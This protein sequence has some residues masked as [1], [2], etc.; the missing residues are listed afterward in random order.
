M[1][2]RRRNSLTGR[3]Y[4]SD[5]TIGS[6][7]LANEPRPMGKRVAF[8]AWVDDTSKLIKSL[9]PHHLVTIGSE[10]AH[11]DVA[12]TWLGKGEA[13][14][15]QQ[16]TSGF[17]ADHAV[18]GIDYMTCHLWL[19]P[20]G[21]MDQDEG[22]DGFRKG[23]THATQYLQAHLQAA[24][25]V[26]KP[27]VVSELGLARDG[28]RHGPTGAV[29]RRDR[30]FRAVFDAMQASVDARDALAG[31]GFSGWAGEGRRKPQKEP[32]AVDVDA[33][34]PGN[35]VESNAFD[36]SVYDFSVYDTDASTVSLVSTYARRWRS[37]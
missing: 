14:T 12:E 7:E 2:L 35:R 11:A 3:V 22:E 34:A 1:L 36:S 15:W 8:R 21:W 28:E 25:R 16:S 13:L 27:L 24:I 5:P 37:E 31:V 29:D 18:Q 6:F 30:L 17:E 32:R 26:G 4:G 20:W 23:L 19:E 33:A 9:A 10:G